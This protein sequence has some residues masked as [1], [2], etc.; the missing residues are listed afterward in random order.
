MH[1]CEAELCQSV[2]THAIEQSDMQTQIHHNIICITKMCTDQLI[3]MH[4]CHKIN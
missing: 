3:G 4:E 2:S 1:M